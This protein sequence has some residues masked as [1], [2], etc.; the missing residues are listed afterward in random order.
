MRLK[1]PIALLVIVAAC[2]TTTK[3]KYGQFLAGY[4]A[5]LN[6]LTAARKAGKINDEDWAEIQTAGKAAKAAKETLDTAYATGNKDTFEVAL[7]AA[8]AALRV[9][10][11]EKK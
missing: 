3:G 1:I 8:E 6:T 11:Q 4:T 9:L 10:E 7:G 5:T 2:A